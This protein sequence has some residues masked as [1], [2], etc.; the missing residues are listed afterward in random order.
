MLQWSSKLYKQFILL[1]GG[2]DH[3]QKILNSYRIYFWMILVSIFH[4]F[5]QFIRI[6]GVEE[7]RII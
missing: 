5:G 7:V 1:Y 2:R 3:A 6:L 4:Y